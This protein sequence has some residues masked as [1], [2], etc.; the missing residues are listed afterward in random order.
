[1]E[2][3]GKKFAELDSKQ[4]AEYI[5][6]YYKFHIIGG[7][8]AI[9]LLFAVLNHYIFNPPKEV[10]ADIT[11]TAPTVNLGGMEELEKEIIGVVEEKYP[12]KTA[13]IEV[14]YF[15]NENDPQTQ[16]MMTTKLISKATAGELSYLI[17]DRENLNFFIEN[18][19]LVPVSEYMEPS[20]MQKYAKEQITAEVDGKETVVAIQIKKDSRIAKLLPPEMEAYLAIYTKPED[21]VMTGDILRR[22]LAEEAAGN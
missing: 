14:L 10:I 12:K 5:M 22:L 9:V 8:A 18:S 1:M 15:S 13:L 20:E 19:G 4:K 7:I 6:E 17:L 16:M 2:R 21:E 3:Y 11:V